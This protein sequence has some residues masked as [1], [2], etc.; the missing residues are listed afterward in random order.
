M[1]R[2]VSIL[3]KK[4]LQRLTLTST[5][6]T[7]AKFKKSEPSIVLASDEENEIDSVSDTMYI[8]MK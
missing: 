5:Q 2:R 7:L 8:P 1:F 6:L 4:T 3:K